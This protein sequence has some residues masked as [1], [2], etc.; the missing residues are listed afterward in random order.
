MQNDLSLAGYGARLNV[1]G[2][3]TL[4]LY[5]P[6]VEIW[7]MLGFFFYIIC[8]E[9]DSNF[10]LSSEHLLRTCGQHSK[11]N[12]WTPQNTKRTLLASYLYVFSTYTF[13]KQLHMEVSVTSS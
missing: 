1:F 11:L 5:C 8:G 12:D 7:N 4:V 6:R 13:A 2:S 10:I 3:T 9:A